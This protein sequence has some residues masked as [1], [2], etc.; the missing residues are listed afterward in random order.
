[1][2]VTRSMNAVSPE[3]TQRLDE[4]LMIVHATLAAIVGDLQ[5]YSGKAAQAVTAAMKELSAAHREMAQLQEPG[6]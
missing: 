1:M 6:R 5:R 3:S 2:R 4:D